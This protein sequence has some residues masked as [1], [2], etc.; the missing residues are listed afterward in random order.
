MWVPI[1][2]ENCW[3]WNINYYPDKPL[4]E[5]ERSMMKEGAGI[6][7][8][9]IPGTYLPVANK[10]NDYLIDRKAQKEN[11]AYSGIFETRDSDSSLQESMG[12]IQDHDIETLVG[13]DVA[14]IKVRDVLYDAAI[15]VQKG[16]VPPA[17]DT[18]S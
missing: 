12:P 13:T 14:I 7:G 8:P 18:K 4:A 15:N 17:L 2:D 3:T 16:A 5:D 11:R 9:A 10:G 6:H 1:D